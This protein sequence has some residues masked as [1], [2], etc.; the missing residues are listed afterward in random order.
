[1]VLLN[2]QPDQSQRSI[3]LVIEPKVSKANSPIRDRNL[4]CNYLIPNSN[5]PHGIQEADGSIPFSSMFSL[6]LERG[7][8]NCPAIRPTLVTGFFVGFGL[9]TLNYMKHPS[10]PHAFQRALLRVVLLGGFVA[11]MAQLA[12]DYVS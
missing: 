2:R 4:S 8:A 3:F 6:G 1:M 7:F 11:G 9:P 12:G 10:S 5:R